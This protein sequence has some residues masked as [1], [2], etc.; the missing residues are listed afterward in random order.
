MVKIARRHRKAVFHRFED[1]P[2][3]AGME[4]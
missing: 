4:E 3:C 2:G 1:I